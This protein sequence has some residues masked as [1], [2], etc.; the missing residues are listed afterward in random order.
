VVIAMSIKNLFQVNQKDEN[1]NEIQKKITDLENQVKRI[2]TL[3]VQLQQFS[4]L[5]KQ[6]GLLNLKNSLGK[7]AVDSKK[8]HQRST[9]TNLDQNLFEKKIRVEMKDMFRAEMKDMFRAEMKDMFR[10]EMITLHQKIGELYG[11]ID[12]LEQQITS[13]EKK[14]EE[15]DMESHICDNEENKNDEQANFTKGQPIIFQEIK[16]DKL[17]V[18]KYEQTNNLGQV[19]IKELSGHLNIGATYD[20][21]VIP[22]DL[23]DEWKQEMSKISKEKNEESESNTPPEDKQNTD[24]YSQVEIDDDGSINNGV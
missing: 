14:I 20:K 5:E 6:L 17:F 3:E 19:G 7:N 10:A 1:F 8:Q 18:D 9:H 2:N 24:Q 11:R 12:F 22:N 4:K 21:G 23:V 13:L 16:V 15:K